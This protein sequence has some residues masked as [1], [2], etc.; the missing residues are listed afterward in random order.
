MAPDSSDDSAPPPA[1]LESQLTQRFYDELHDLAQR[2]FVRERSDH[3]LQPTALVNEACM[4]LMT[5]SPL[6]DLPREQRLAL[7]ARVLKQVLVDH[8]RAKGSQKRGAGRLRIEL[9]AEL[10]EER[11]TIVDFEAVHAAL[12]Q[13]ERLSPRQAQ[14][15]SLRMFGGLS[16]PE[17]AAQLGVSLRTAEGDWA[18]ARA[19]LRREL[20]GQI[21]GECERAP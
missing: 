12:E 7:A 17:I 20:R 15:V 6:P 11:P 9:D 8:A 18:V 13:L 3:T 5:S 10:G 14:V 21:D 19:W 1:P 4:R 2:L 16:M